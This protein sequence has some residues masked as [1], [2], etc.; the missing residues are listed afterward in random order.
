LSFPPYCLPRADSAFLDQLSL[1]QFVFCGIFLR[2]PLPNSSLFFFPSF[3]SPPDSPIL[4]PKIYRVPARWLRFGG[5]RWFPPMKSFFSTQSP[6]IPCHFL[7][8]RW[9]GTPLFPSAPPP[10]PL[11]PHLP[12]PARL[13]S[14]FVSAA[15]F[16]P[17][18]VNLPSL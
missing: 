4:P 17:P 7:P 12:L 11:P 16:F 6:L 3:R 9:I 5:H 8:C 1:P 10:Y 13:T 18:V 2:Q 15:F 14:F